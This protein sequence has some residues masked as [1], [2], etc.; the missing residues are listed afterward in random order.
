MTLPIEDGIN[1]FLAER[2]ES[3][4]AVTSWMF[5]AEYLDADSENCLVFGI[6]EGQ[7][8]V[9]TVGLAEVGHAQAREAQFEALSDWRK[10]D[11]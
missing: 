3:A 7:G 2:G 9:T 5:V 8:I 11:E 6:P 4:V 1:A 10:D